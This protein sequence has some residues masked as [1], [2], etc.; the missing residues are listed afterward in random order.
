MDLSAVR[1][2]YKQQLFDISDADIDPLQQ[3]RQ[4]LVDAERA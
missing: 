4:W 2:E 3:L 1:E